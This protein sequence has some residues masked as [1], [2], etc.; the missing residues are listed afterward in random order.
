MKQ[1]K[2]ELDVDFIGGTGP[3]TEEESKAISAYIKAQKDKKSVN[4]VQN[5][6]LP[7][8]Q[9]VLKRLRSK[10]KSAPTADEI[11]KEVELVRAKRNVK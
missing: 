8:K 6:K 7:P 1:N 3:L 5:K 10:A 11:T 4:K 9:E 2:N